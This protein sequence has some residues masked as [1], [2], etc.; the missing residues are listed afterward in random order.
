[1]DS[2]RK[3][4]T[5]AAANRDST[6]LVGINRCH[7]GKRRCLCANDRGRK[8]CAV[9]NCPAF[10]GVPCFL[11]PSQFK[12]D[13]AKSNRERV[14]IRVSVVVHCHHLLGRWLLLLESDHAPAGSL[15]ASAAVRNAVRRSTCSRGRPAD[16]Q[17][18]LRTTPIPPCQLRLVK[19]SPPGPTR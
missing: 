13:L 16:D 5:R 15:N 12:E 3:G 6:T 7:V 9:A 4:V 8:G 11:A 17:R 10:I 18:I 1:M 19:T 2:A 14:L